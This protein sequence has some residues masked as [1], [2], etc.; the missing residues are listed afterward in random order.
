MQLRYS[1]WVPPCVS[2]EAEAGPS[3]ASTGPCKVD[4]SMSLRCSSRE[5]VSCSPQCAG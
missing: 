3:M 2:G 4:R 5:M 1:R